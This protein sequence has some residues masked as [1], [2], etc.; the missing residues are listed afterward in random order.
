MLKTRLLH[1]GILE[2][3]GEA[4]WN[5]INLALEA[6]DTAEAGVE[7]LEAAE[8][9]LNPI[10]AGEHDAP[11]HVPRSEGRPLLVGKAPARAPRWRRREFRACR[12]SGHAR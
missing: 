8:L 5:K 12:S 11:E 7:A 10:H 4:K 6:P 9:R 2:A 1:P 3:L